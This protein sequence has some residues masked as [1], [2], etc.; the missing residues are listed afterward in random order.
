M[1]GLGIAWNGGGGFPSTLLQ[2]NQYWLT[3][4]VAIFF[5][6]GVALVMIG[7]SH[8]RRNAARA[9]GSA[10]LVMMMVLFVIDLFLAFFTIS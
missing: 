8:G 1:S 7:I 10:F 9:M 5:I 3:V 2:G 6:L 4:L